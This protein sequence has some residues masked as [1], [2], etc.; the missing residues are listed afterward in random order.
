MLYIPP[1]SAREVAI[2][3]IDPG[4]DTLGISA[5]W[6]DIETLA[7]KRLYA[8]T[9]KASQRSR[10]M[11]YRDEHG[12][13]AARIRWHEENLFNLLCELNPVAVVSESPFFSV[14]FPSAYGALTEVVD[15]IKS[16]MWRWRPTA[17][18]TLID[19]PTVKNAVGVKGNA[20]KEEVHAGLVNYLR[21]EGGERIFQGPGTLVALDEHATDASAVGICYLERLRRGEV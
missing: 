16:A 9:Y 4:S 8:Q 15:A 14:R 17:V 7:L 5:S 10:N 3:G 2:V 12:D 1:D 21:Q 13:R 19:P 11:W 18:L 20:G 6:V